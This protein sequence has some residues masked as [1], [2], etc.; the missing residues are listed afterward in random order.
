MDLKYLD[1]SKYN[2]FLF[3]DEVLWLY[4]TN[5]DVSTMWSVRKTIP[6]NLTMSLTSIWI[7]GINIHHT[8]GP[9]AIRAAFVWQKQF[10]DK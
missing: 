9:N 4:I 7:T 5:D 10:P 1:Q 3:Y 2:I 8:K 6:F